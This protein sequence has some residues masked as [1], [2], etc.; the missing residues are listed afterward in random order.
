MAALV[1]QGMREGASGFPRVSS[2]TS[3]AMPPPTSSSSS[4]RPA[5]R[6]GG[7]YMTHS[8]DEADKSFQAIAEAIEIGDRG[9]L[10]L[11]ISHIK[12]AT[13]GV[14]GKAKE[15]VALVDKARAKGQDVTADCYPYLAWHSNIEVLVPNKQYDDPK[16]VQEALDVIGG[17]KNVTIT[18]CKA[19]PSY[20]GRDLAQ[21][22]KAE[23][24]TPVAL[25]SRIV[26][27]G[28]ADVIGHTMM[29]KGRR[30]LL[31]ASPG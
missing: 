21:I 31:Q 4:R 5:A 30:G 3:A 18:A 24:V 15:A 26:K 2:T 1:D 6:F 13:T 17:A 10:P 19:H 9:G 25:Y 12:L 16:S 7:F 28:G 29:T 20:A 14:W 8:R 27:D 23:G 22:A 11:D